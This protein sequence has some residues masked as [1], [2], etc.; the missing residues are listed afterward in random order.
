MNRGKRKKRNAKSTNKCR[1]NNRS[2]RTTSKNIHTKVCLHY[3]QGRCN[4]GN[5][6]KFVHGEWENATSG[7][8]NISSSVNSCGDCDE[9]TKSQSI[10]K[11]KRGKQRGRRSRHFKAYTSKMM[12]NCKQ[13]ESSDTTTGRC[14]ILT[15]LCDHNLL[16]VLFNLNIPDLG[17]TAICC[18]KWNYMMKENANHCNSYGTSIWRNIYN[19]FFSPPSTL[20]SM[21]LKSYFLTST[22]ST[23][24]TSTWKNK[25]QDR[26][27]VKHRWLRK[28][29]YDHSYHSSDRQ[30][31]HVGEHQEFQ[32]I[33]NAL[34]CASAFDQIIVHPGDY[35]DDVVRISTSVEIVGVNDVKTKD[36]YEVNESKESNKSKYHSS[37][38]KTIFGSPTSVLIN[39]DLD[40][41]SHLT[42]TASL[43]TFGAILGKIFIYPGAKVR[44][45]LVQFGG[46]DSVVSFN[47]Q[48]N[49]RIKC[50]SS[51]MKNTWCQFDECTF[52]N[53]LFIYERKT[54]NVQLNQCIIVGC[55][56]VLM[57]NNGGPGIVRP[58][59]IDLPRLDDEEEEIVDNEEILGLATFVECV[60]LP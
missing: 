56:S 47:G 36:L 31:F 2:K 40:S 52:N 33:Q 57:G 22:K 43:S 51:F 46:D 26:I 44:F 15:K 59:G 37:S 1:T 13:K 17:R 23:S 18:T 41:I 30:T 48:D 27:D 54:P 39:D 8:N 6:C 55:D 11:T 58:F 4:W 24:K 29:N 45:S 34:L 38:R 9:P 50:N 12:L 53:T 60:G 14:S 21:V 10:A 28:A 16:E 5:Q 32:T 35:S 25:V 19:T 7:S 49:T 42:R 20:Y 3:I